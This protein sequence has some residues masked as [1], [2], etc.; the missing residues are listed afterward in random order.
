M[1]GRPEDAITAYE[2][3]LERDPEN[4]QAQG[5]LALALAAAGQGT[6]ALTIFDEI[7]GRE[8][9]APLDYYNA[10]VSLYQV[11]RFEQAVVGFEKALERAPI[12]RDALQNLRKPSV[13]CRTTKPKS[14]LGEAPR[15]GS[16]Q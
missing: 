5:S 1:A 7:L 16:L 6:D 10:A 8:D 3:L 13:R 12:Y 15:V 4:I 11:E 14:L 9:A 2:A